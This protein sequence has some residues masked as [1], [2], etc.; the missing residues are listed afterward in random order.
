MHRIYMLCLFLLLAAGAGNAQVVSS[1]YWR[2][3]V[4]TGKLYFRMNP[5]GLIDFFDMNFTI[6]GEYRINHTW[7]ATM[8]AG[9]IFFSQYAGR[10]KS[11]SGILL[12]PGIRKYAGKRKDFFL[13]LQFQYKVVNYRV[14]DWLEKN[15]VNDVATYEEYKNFRYYKRVFGGHFMIG[16]RE[17]LSKNRRWFFEVYAGIGLHFKKEGMPDETNSR[18][19]ERNTIRVFSNTSGVTNRI[20]PAFPA[21]IR[22]VFRFR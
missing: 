19:E 22:L 4:D 12:R 16:G 8:D 15:V 7:S 21:G 5:A 6:G 1:K 20:S 14:E 17:Y 9:Y 11:A 10:V 18:Y 13:D 3:D 2:A